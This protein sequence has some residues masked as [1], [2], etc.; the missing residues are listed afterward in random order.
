MEVLRALNAANLASSFGKRVVPFGRR[1][2][3][4]DHFFL[5]RSRRRDDSTRTHAEGID[6][7]A[8]GLGGQGVGG[9]G[10]VFAANGTMVLDGVNDGLRMFD[11]D[12]ECERFGFDSNTSSPHLLS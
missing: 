8:F 10:K 6:P 4:D 5:R 2:S 9:R 7:A 1:P 12:S 11:A 3:V